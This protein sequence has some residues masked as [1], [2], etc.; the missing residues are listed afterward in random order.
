M[1]S[2]LAALALCSC[3]AGVTRPL[4]I[5]SS[6]KE[7]SLTGVRPI[8]WNNGDVLFHVIAASHMSEQELSLDDFVTCA[9]Y[10]NVSI[11]STNDSCT[12]ILNAFNSAL[13]SQFS[14]DGTRQPVTLL[15]ID[16][17]RYNFENKGHKSDPRTYIPVYD[18]RSNSDTLSTFYHEYYHVNYAR[19]YRR[20]WISSLVG[21]K[22]RLA[23]EEISATLFSVCA[24]ERS[25]AEGRPVRVPDVRALS[26]EK[27]GS[28]SQTQKLLGFK[29][30][31]RSLDDST[32]TSLCSNLL[33]APPRTYDDLER[34]LTMLSGTT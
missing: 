29:N 12:S 20:S 24:R 3:V 6:E 15:L 17:L 21:G 27:Q 1:A 26:N 34:H 14:T 10:G 16:S 22:E 32:L 7:Y 18:V 28:F 4:P 9:T 33:L 25:K 30:F 11:A 31:A 23:V 8:Q 5:M 13:Y 2:V 19:E